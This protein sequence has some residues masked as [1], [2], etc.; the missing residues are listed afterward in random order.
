M[1]ASEYIIEKY[2]AIE[3]IAN[4]IA[5]I[6]SAVARFPDLEV[7]ETRKIGRKFISKSSESVVENVEYSHSCGCCPDAALY[8]NCCVVIDDIKIFPSLHG[9]SLGETASWYDSGYEIADLEETI[10]NV[11]A[12]RFPPDL[13]RKII[14][15]CRSID[16]AN[17]K[18]YAFRQQLKESLKND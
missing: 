13:K 3:S 18:Q 8:A 1:K 10:S 11:E 16:E 9:V 12:T 17:K 7:I 4:D 5:K 14:S 15:R 6:Q 2:K